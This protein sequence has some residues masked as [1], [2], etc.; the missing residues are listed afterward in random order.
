MS[1]PLDDS[2]AVRVLR[3]LRSGPKIAVSILAVTLALAVFGEA[4]AP[5]D[6]L[7]INPR[8]G[9]LPPVFSEGGIWAHPLGTDRQGRD[10]LSRVMVGTQYSMAVAAAVLLAGGLVGCV[11]GMIAGYRGG[12][13]DAALMRIVDASLT[14]PGILLA[15]VLVASIGP[16]FWVVVGVLAFSMWPRFARLMRAEVLA[17]KNRDFVALARV[18]G[19]PDWYII[20]RHILPNTVNAIVVLA[21]LQIG[22]AIVI[23]AT[24]GFLGV[25]IPPPTATWGNIIADGRSYILSAWWIS[26]F[27]GITITLVVLAFNNFGD[28]LRDYL[29]PTLRQL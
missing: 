17:C 24:L 27:P 18:A 12:L 8:L 4:L 5:H 11:W 9:E 23:E 10:V 1:G 16:G 6:P 29:D 7:A 15:L 22:Y 13:V 19:A 3:A 21:T 14:F 25:G 28:W 20:L 26:F 2:A